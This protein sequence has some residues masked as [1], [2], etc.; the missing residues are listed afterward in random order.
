MNGQ[1]TT[2][3]DSLV[4]AQFHLASNVGLHLTAQVTFDLEVGVDVV[5]QSNQLLVREVLDADVLVDFGLVEN[6]NRTGAANAV[7][8]GECD[9]HALVAGNIY[10]SETCHEAAP[11]D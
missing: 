1:T 8:V 2:V 10:S 6:L 4:R 11:S 5:T 9:F 7:N 3:S